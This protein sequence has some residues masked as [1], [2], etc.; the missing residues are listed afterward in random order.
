MERH[1]ATVLN[2]TFNATLGGALPYDS[3][4]SGRA[5]GKASKLTRA[6][7]QLGSLAELFVMRA[8]DTVK[9]ATIRVLTTMDHGRSRVVSVRE[10]AGHGEGCARE[11]NGHYI[12]LTAGYVQLQ[13]G[14]LLII[15]DVMGLASAALGGVVY[16][17]YVIPPEV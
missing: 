5:T 13:L 6:V 2:S 17:V 11:G 14:I 8:G 15:K 3:G 4:F 9:G 1:V 12:I 7:K 16:L 10:K